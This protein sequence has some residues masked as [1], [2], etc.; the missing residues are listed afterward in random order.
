MSDSPQRE[1]APDPIPPTE[2]PD[3]ILRPWPPVGV[4]ALWEELVALVSGAAASTLRSRILC[5][6]SILGRQMSTFT[7]RQRC[8]GALEILDHLAL[9]LIEVG[10]DRRLQRLT[11]RDIT[12]RAEALAML[13]R[14]L[15]ICRTRV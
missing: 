5:R 14:A 10:L 4:P 7:T 3:T 2:P 12:G 1:G 13:D 15:Y 8:V 9:G 6:D 11:G